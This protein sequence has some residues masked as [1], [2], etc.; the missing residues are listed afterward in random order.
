[1]LRLVWALRES[2][3]EGLKPPFCYGHVANGMERAGITLS[4]LR[5]L[6]AQEAAG[7]DRAGSFSWEGQVTSWPHGDRRTRRTLGHCSPV[8]ISCCADSSPRQHLCFC[9]MGSS[10]STCSLS[11]AARLG[12]GHRPLLLWRLRCS[13][14]A[15]REWVALGTY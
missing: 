15:A 3:L 8:V 4:G 9:V 1:M 11:R 13:C 14:G 10:R 6:M 5:R 2:A 12:F 7:G